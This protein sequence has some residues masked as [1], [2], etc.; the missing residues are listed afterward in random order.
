MNFRRGDICVVAGDGSGITNLTDTPD[1]NERTPAWSPNGTRI[2][3]VRG[4]ADHGQI[5]VMNADG[6]NQHQV[7]SVDDSADWPSWSPNGD[8]I[9]YS[10][11]KGSTH[12]QVWVADADGTNAAAITTGETY[13]SSEPAWSP[14]G[15]QIA[16]SSD[17]D[18]NPDAE[19]PVEWN[20]EIYV[21][22]TDGTG[23][24]RI[25]QL[26]GNDHWP[27]AWSADGKSLAFTADGSTNIGDIY[28]VRL[29][30]TPINITT[31]KAVDAFPAWRPQP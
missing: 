4:D 17:R 1:L 9:V 29:G 19:N 28:V 31:N 10:S 2:V 15:E 22:N 24:R 21:M 3:Y 20:E 26:P 27:P 25:T 30:G 23:T 16:F 8:R 11:S 7:T 14:T 12:E 18:G 6:S 13:G 5:Y